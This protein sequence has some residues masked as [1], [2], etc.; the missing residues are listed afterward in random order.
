[1]HRAT[2][3]HQAAVFFPVHPVLLAV[4]LVSVFSLYLF[5]A[6]WL[7]AQ[8]ANT[9][10]GAD[11][12]HYSQIAEGKFYERSLRFHPVT[13]L[14]AFGWMK[15]FQ[16]LTAW[17]DPFLI[18]RAMFALVGTL[19]VW[20]AIS[21]FATM[22]G[23]RYAALLGIVYASTLGIWYFSSIEE[24]KIVSATLAAIYVAI[25]LR[26]RK[27]WTSHRA[28]ALTAV[29]LVACLNE[30]VAGLLVF[31]PALDALIRRGLN[32][33][34]LRWLSLHAAAGVLALVLLEILTRLRPDD[35]SAEST[36]HL[37]LLLWYITQN[38]YSFQKFYEFVLRWFLFNL[39]API[40]NLENAD[41]DK[42]FGGDFVPSIASYFASPAGIFL[43]IVA[44]AIAVISIWKRPRAS[45]PRAD[46]AIVVA[47]AVYILLRTT[48]FFVSL[49]GEHMLFAPSITLALLL[50]VGRPLMAS[51]FSGTGYL[52]SALA[53]A[54]LWANGTFIFAANIF[55]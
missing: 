41:P 31:I 16:P 21:A 4:I 53:I 27:D 36:S 19:G 47:L 9:Y 11:G 32:W 12:W 34:D 54:L 15:I 7:G 18:L 46:I 44:V 48:F 13:V 30:I 24:T 20:A 49:P 39:A 42:G 28:I 37:G 2:R 55:P 8:Y 51:A 52:L 17:L 3:E 26:L 35:A 25:Y 6:Q 40:A 45:A 1:L 5:S 43:F 22:F 50:I 10:F 14:A 23:S 38:E 29:L 33:R